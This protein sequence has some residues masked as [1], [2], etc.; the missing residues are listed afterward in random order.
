MIT[1]W[2]LVTFVAYNSGFQYSPPVA[3]QAACE[4]MKIEAE[5]KRFSNNNLITCIK[6]EIHK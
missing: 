1:A 6:V 5:K 4:A 3:T 2:I